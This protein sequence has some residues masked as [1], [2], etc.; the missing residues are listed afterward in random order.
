[1]I[2][3][4]NDGASV[5]PPP[6]HPPTTPPLSMPAD[7]RCAIGITLLL[8]GGGSA[9]LYDEKYR[10]LFFGR[11]YLNHTIGC[12]INSNITVA[13]P[14]HD[15]TTVDLSGSTLVGAAVIVFAFST[16]HVV[17]PIRNQLRARRGASR[18]DRM[19]CL[20]RVRLAVLLRGRIA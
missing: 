10:S 14:G 2:D 5:D 17:L 13:A 3:C 18:A 19:I 7:G 11:E 12:P 1:M 9:V 6:P 8:G 4:H 20:I 15:I 16:Q